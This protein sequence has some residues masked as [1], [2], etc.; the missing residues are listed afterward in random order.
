M[1]E[2]DI[3]YIVDNNMGCCDGA[4]YFVRLPKEYA[5]LDEHVRAVIPYLISGDQPFIVAVATGLEWL[6]RPNQWWGYDFK[7]LE[8]GRLA[9]TLSRR[10]PITTTKDG[11][12]SVRGESRD[13]PQEVQ[14]SADVL[15][16]KLPADWF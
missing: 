13:A 6:D 3:V 15:L 16:D 11:V 9:K 12:R 7:D 2:N 1:S 10:E 8:L 5:H 14:D 4:T